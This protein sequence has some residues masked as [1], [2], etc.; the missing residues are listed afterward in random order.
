MDNVEALLYTKRMVKANAYKLCLASVLLGA[1]M[2]LVELLMS[3]CAN[4]GVIQG[5]PRDTL[6]PVLIVERSTPNR[7]VHFRPREIILHFDEWIQ[8]HNPTKEIFITPPLQGRYEIK[9]HG[10][11][12][13]MRFSPETQWQERTTYLIHFGRAIRD[14]HE[15]NPAD[16]I[17]YVFST[18]A[19]IDSLQ[20]SG[21]IVDVES[22]IPVE[23]ATVLLYAVRKDSP[24]VRDLPDYMSFS[25]HNGEFLFPHLRADSFLVLAVM[26]K[27]RNYKVDFE[28]ERHG[29]YPRAIKSTNPPDSLEIV[30]F[31]PRVKPRVL[32][33]MKNAHA[34]KLELSSVPE[35]VVIQ[36]EPSHIP[37]RHTVV[38]DTLYIVWGPDTGG[39][40]ERVYLRFSDQQ[41][42]TIDVGELR[43]T[44]RWPEQLRLVGREGLLTE[45]EK[46]WR[47]EFNQPV[48]WDTT[49]VDLMS[50]GQKIEP[51][52]WTL[53]PDTT[54]WIWKVH[55]PWQHTQSYEC[56]V[57]PGGWRALSG[58]S[59]TDTIV[60]SLPTVDERELGSYTIRLH[61]G[62][63]AD[64]RSSSG[65]VRLLRD[66]H[67]W[68]E[69]CYS[70]EDTLWQVEWKFLPPGTYHFI[71]IRDLDADCQ[72]D[73]GD[74]LR[75]KQ[76]EGIT[77]HPLPPLR[78]NWV[79]VIDIYEGEDKTKK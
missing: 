34:L 46:G 21:R 38:V 55:Y 66:N 31:S 10:K 53:I 69:R 20:L 71:H 18:G 3:G 29:F 16:S 58:Q 9:A 47:L 62:A 60:F 27:N 73:T 56:V 74:W 36:L 14:L 68:R 8:L 64:E 30:L 33:A 28:V 61:L 50:D 45:T 24:V 11:R 51:Q 67:V 41:S 77:R 17:L 37:F 6:P 13:M 44:F 63:N 39:R 32:R 19:V 54:G 78:A 70:T 35:S 72:W 49:L 12:V 15:G 2:A 26:D 23:G 75:L 65:I 59:P 25:N 48:L 43:R 4:R 52:Q 76:P 79:T 40:I 22:H 1:A 42:D 57:Y 5:G 7:Q